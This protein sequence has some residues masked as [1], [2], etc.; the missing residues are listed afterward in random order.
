MPARCSAPQKAGARLD[1]TDRGRR[2]RHR[3]T[4]GC[5]ARGPPGRGQRQAEPTEIRARFVVAADG[6]A[7]AVRQAG[8]RR[9]ATTRG[10]WGSPRAATTARATTRDRGSS[11]GSTCGRATCCCPGYGWLFPVAGGADQPRRRTAQH[12]QELQ[13]RLRAAAVRRVRHDAPAEWG[14][15]EE[16][17][18]GRLLSGPLPMSFNRSPQAVP[19]MLL[20]GDAAG[21]V[22][23]FNGEG[24]AYAMETGEMAA[25]LV[26]EALVQR[27][28]G[29]HDDVPDGAPRALRR[30]TS[31]SAGGSRA[32]SGKPTIMG[33]ATRFMLPRPRGDELRAPGDGEP[34]RRARR[35]RAGPALLSAGAG[36]EGAS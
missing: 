35:R 14:I 21:A 10:R 26:H 15:T 29:P 17:A 2:A 16:T 3:R 27:P 1:G 36:R 12:V 4:G 32:W 33:R 20:V 6:A 13:G 25:E 7:G 11:R 19:G 34:Q 5:A 8:R 24:I 9:A 23:P 31:R 28:A 18:E 22:N 30:G